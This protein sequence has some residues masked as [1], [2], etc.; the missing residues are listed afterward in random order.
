MML[1]QGNFAPQGTL[2][3]FWKHFCHK[4]SEGVATGIPQHTE[5]ITNNKDLFVRENIPHAKVEVATPL[6]ME[7]EIYI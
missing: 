7:G 6:K 1:K 3:N 5:K 4:C 2:E